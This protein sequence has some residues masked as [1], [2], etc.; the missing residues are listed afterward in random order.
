MMKD[1]Q[2]RI[3]KRSEKIADESYRDFWKKHTDLGGHVFEGVSLAELAKALNDMQYPGGDNLAKSLKITGDADIRKVITMYGE[4]LK[5][6]VM[7]SERARLEEELL[8][9]AEKLNG[10][11]IEPE[12]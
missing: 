2:E 4:L 10:G 6:A 8:E 7:V 1:L 5:A 9:F 11:E 12:A 3:N